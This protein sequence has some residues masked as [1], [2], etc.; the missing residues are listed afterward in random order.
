MNKSYQTLL[1]N[2]IRVHII[3]SKKYKTT[4]I[5]YRLSTFI[6]P[7]I[8]HIIMGLS[9]FLLSNTS[10]C[11]NRKEINRYLENMY[12]S[13][14]HCT[15]NAFGNISNCEF[16]IK[17]INQKYCPDKNLFENS[18]KFL[19]D[20]I[21]GKYEGKNEFKED[22]VNR[23][24]ESIV[25][26]IKVSKE[27][28]TEYGLSL[29]INKMCKNENIDIINFNNHLK[30]KKLTIKEIKEVYTYLIENANMDL[31]IS[32]DLE[33]INVEEILK[34]NLPKYTKE[35]EKIKVD[36]NNSNKNIKKV[37]YYEKI[38][39]NNQT[40]LFLGYRNNISYNSKDIYIQNLS[41]AILGGFMNSRLFRIVREKYN[42]C[43]SVF[44]FIRPLNKLMFIY[45]GIDDKN[46]DKT[47]NIIKKIVDDLSKRKLTENELNLFKKLLI[48][49]IKESEDSQYNQIDKIYS[50]I[51]GDAE[52]DINK[53][54][55][56]INSVT[57]LEVKE[58][59]K[60]IKLDAIFS[61]RGVLNE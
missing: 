2:N 51:Y 10:E 45:A 23:E 47:I 43:Y 14:I 56:H 58:Y 4:C 46:K 39:N 30:F 60:S 17:T 55:D 12:D 20:I 27:N 9:Y 41:N 24:I 26:E 48:N 40:H 34:N 18:I 35:N 13:K 25:N 22:L 1:I 44:S 11:Q 3:N 37:K 61:L 50:H 38:E 7:K 52:I 15:M 36:L 54:I 59:F 31:F 57:S 32:G 42:L 21:F 53:T 49:S 8:S 29:L 33:G 16:V 28:K 5:S 19:L 6:D